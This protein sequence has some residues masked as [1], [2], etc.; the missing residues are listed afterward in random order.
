MFSACLLS[1]FVL[2]QKNVTGCMFAPND[3]NLLVSCGEDGLLAC[4][5]RRTKQVR[6][7]LGAQ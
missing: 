6:R 5:D 1:L 7:Q 3:D 2:L 4:T